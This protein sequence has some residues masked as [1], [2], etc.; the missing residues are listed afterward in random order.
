MMEL[1]M[2]KVRHDK[3]LEAAVN[4]ALAATLLVDVSA[5]V[6]VLAN[7]EVPPQI[8]MRVLLEPQHRRASDWRH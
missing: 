7:E 4:R 2:G 3:K 8:A 6:K 1:T 5:G